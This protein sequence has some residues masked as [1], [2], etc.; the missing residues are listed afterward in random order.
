MSAAIKNAEELYDWFRSCRLS[1][2]A[3]ELRERGIF[4]T[5]AVRRGV[6]VDSSQGRILLDGTFYQVLFENM[7][8]GVYRAYIGIG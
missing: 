2:R 8:G 5:T 4:V 6:M 7:G 1:H 3:E